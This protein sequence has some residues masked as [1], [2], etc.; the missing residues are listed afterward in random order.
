M[1]RPCAPGEHGEQF[2]LRDGIS[3]FLRLCLCQR[4]LV[5][6]LGV[7]LQPATWGQTAAVI[8]PSVRKNSE[9]P[10]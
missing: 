5:R 3:S 1:G 10:D 9:I 6:S 8:S 2:Y 7:I 4:E